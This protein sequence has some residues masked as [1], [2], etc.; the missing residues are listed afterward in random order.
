MNADSSGTSPHSSARPAAGASEPA[1]NAHPRHRRVASVLRG[2]CEDPDTLVN[3]L[4]H[5]RI[6]DLLGLPES[7]I[8][9]LNSSRPALRRRFALHLRRRIGLTR[10]Q[11]SAA[12]ELPDDLRELVYGIYLFATTI[13][14][15]DTPRILP[16]ERMRALA[17]SYGEEPLSF[18]LTQRALLRDSAAA[19]R[20]VITGE[21]PSETDQ[22]LFIRALA[23]HGHPAA[24]CIAL[25]L[26]L[27]VSLATRTI[28]DR[29]DAVITGLPTLAARALAHIREKGAP[30]MARPDAHP[31]ATAGTDPES[32]TR[33][34]DEWR[35]DA[36]AEADG[37]IVTQN[38]AASPPASGEGDHDRSVA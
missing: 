38:D 25:M 15:A 14:L 21:P 16:R 6:A 32:I 4:G 9:T 24:A 23:A 22:R 31:T 34:E 3:L 29:F 19:L 11:V 26:G 10:L 27:P 30:P 28:E 5:E 17:A 18:A 37:D 35:R 1:R 20:E 36:A 33:Q 8:S 12:K 13:R 2:A 7:A